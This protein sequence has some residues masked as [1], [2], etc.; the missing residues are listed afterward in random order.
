VVYEYLVGSICEAK[1]LL[2][3]KPSLKHFHVM[4]CVYLLQVPYI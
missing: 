2:R 3:D 4:G 1:I